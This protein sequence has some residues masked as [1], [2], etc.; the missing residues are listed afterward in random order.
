MGL[1]VAIADA[2]II[3]AIPKPAIFA[4]AAQALLREHVREAFE[5]TREPPGSIAER[6]RRRPGRVR[7]GDATLGGGRHDAQHDSASALASKM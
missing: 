1:D 5:C 7:G 2:M 3:C 6:R 4:C